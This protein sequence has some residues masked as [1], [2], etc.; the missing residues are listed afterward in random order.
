MEERIK[1]RLEYLRKQIEKECISYSEVVELQSLKKYAIES[2]DN[3]LME[4][5]GVEE[6]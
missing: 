1:A 2:G 6:N 4:W 3:A 5:A